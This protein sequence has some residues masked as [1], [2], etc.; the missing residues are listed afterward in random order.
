VSIQNQAL[1]ILHD[2]ISGRREAWDILFALAKH[3]PNA[4]VA[5]V[6]PSTSFA[7]DVITAIQNNNRVGAI[8]LIRTQF[9]CGL[10][11]AKD[12]MEAAERRLPDEAQAINVLVG[13][14]IPF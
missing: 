5:A 9:S 2:V 6:H 3:N 11:E 4:L 8:K 1:D 12:L 13:G 7:H 14:P 10:K